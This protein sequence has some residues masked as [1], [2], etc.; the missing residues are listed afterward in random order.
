[1]KRALVVVLALVATVAAGC[2]T[3]GQESVLDKE[4]IVVAVRPD[5]PSVGFRR[6]DGRFEGFDVDVAA[7]IARKLGK[8]ATYIP[9]LA[10]DRQKAITDG[11]ADLVLATFTIDQ[12]R[13]KEVL[14]A[15]PYHISYQDILQRPDETIKNV[16]DLKGRR[17]CNVKGSNAADRVV[18][19]REV[20]AQL[21][22]FDDYKTC[23]AALKS[24]RVDAV[25]T[26]DVILAGLANQDGTGLKLANAH[27]N[28]QRT[29]VGMRR[30]DVPGCEAVNRAITEM[31]QDGTASRLLHRWFGTSGLDLS[32]VAVPQFEG[33]S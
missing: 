22:P 5:L 21:V 30:S 14:F 3:D 25:T 24:N 23:L 17:I 1:M 26:N 8:E 4:K 32:T 20:A 13:K 10:A 15:G 28:E 11:R 9:V 2:G 6:P 31:Y 7:Y 29:G 16:R 19:E 12:E 18:K 27:F 33:C